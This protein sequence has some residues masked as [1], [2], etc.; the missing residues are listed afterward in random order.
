MLKKGYKK[1]PERLE[2]I[3][4]SVVHSLGWEKSLLQQQLLLSWPEVVGKEI[5]Q[6]TTPLR[7]RGSK[8]FVEVESS[9]W[10]NHLHYLKPEILMKLNENFKERKIVF[11]RDIIFRCRS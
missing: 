9:S 11:I 3:L 1:K 5:S 6:R 4:K 2:V 10:M 8:L 7:V